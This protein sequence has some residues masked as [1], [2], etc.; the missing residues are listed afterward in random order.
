[1]NIDRP[2]RADLDIA[3]QL[4]VLASEI[5]LRYFHR[6]VSADTKPDGTPV[7]R[8]EELANKALLLKSLSLRLRRRCGRSQMNAGALDAYVMLGLAAFVGA[9]VAVAKRVFAHA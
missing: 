4:V 1:M 8:R 6:C 9:L 3:R 7:S 2:F 5:A